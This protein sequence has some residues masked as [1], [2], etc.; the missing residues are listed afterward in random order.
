MGTMVFPAIDRGWY[1]C[2]CDAHVCWS[3]LQMYGYI[4][5]LFIIFQD[6]FNIYIDN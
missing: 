6:D 2:V 3:R 4:H 1:E 5:K